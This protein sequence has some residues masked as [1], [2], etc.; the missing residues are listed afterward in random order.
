MSTVRHFQGTWFKSCTITTKVVLFSTTFGTGSLCCSWR[1]LKSNVTVWWPLLLIKTFPKTALC[2]MFCSFSSHELICTSY[3]DRSQILPW[4]SPCLAALLT[5]LG[6][7]TACW[8][9]S[10]LRHLPHHTWTPTSYTGSPTLWNPSFP[11]ASL[12]PCVGAPQ[13]NQPPFHL[14]HGHIFV[15]PYLPI[16]GMNCSG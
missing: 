14:T 6:W 4:A 5:P 8:V 16:L 3:F 1:I 13:L 2:M 7:D 15:Q 12:T 10:P 11:H 9:T